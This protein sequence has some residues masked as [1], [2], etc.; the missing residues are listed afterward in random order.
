MHIT[1][2]TLESPNIGL[3]ESTSSR[4]IAGHKK[5]IIRYLLTSFSKIFINIYLAVLDLSCGMQTLS[6][7]M[8]DL[9]HLTRDES[10]ESLEF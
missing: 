10:T 8:S 5:Y 4:A 2:N 9:V 7:S 6:C 3:W 1:S